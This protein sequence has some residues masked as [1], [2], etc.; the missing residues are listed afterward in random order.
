LGSAAF[1]PASA[2]A[3]ASGAAGWQTAL[4]LDFTTEPAQSLAANGAYTIGGIPGWLRSNAANDRV[5]MAIVAGTG[6]VMKPGVAA[7]SFTNIIRT[8]PALWLPFSALGIAGLSFASQIRL[9]I[10]LD[11]GFE[12][13]GVDNRDGSVLSVDTNSTAYIAGMLKPGTDSFGHRQ[14][15]WLAGINGGLLGGSSVNYGT[16]NIPPA[17]SVPPKTNFASI[18]LRS[19]GAGPLNGAMFVTYDLTSVGMPAANAPTNK[20]RLASPGIGSMSSDGNMALLDPTGL[21]AGAFFGVTLGS[22]TLGGNGDKWVSTF[23]R[24]KVEYQLT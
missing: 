24:L 1:Q 4:D 16:A 3:P 7:N 2:F 19:L 6:L 15:E 17:P 22:Y 20:P 13:G 18:T 23:Q 5:A 12:A 14:F 9:S 10:L 8:G 11:D 21:G